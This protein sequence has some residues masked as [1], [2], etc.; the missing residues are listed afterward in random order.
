[1]SVQIKYAKTDNP[2]KKSYEADEEMK[3]I[4]E[5]VWYPSSDYVEE[6][7]KIGLENLH[8][9]AN[10][11]YINENVVAVPYLD[12]TMDFYDVANKK[13]ICTINNIKSVPVKCFGPDSEGNVYIVGESHGYCFDKDYNLIVE[14]DSLKHVD[15]KEGYMVIGEIVGDLWE[16]PIYSMDDLIN[17]AQK[18]VK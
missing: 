1:M 18:E 16:L 2:D 7:D 6:A 12:M 13:V 8:M 15:V 5:G 4:L 14:I 17:L 11:L 10:V 9:V 3:S